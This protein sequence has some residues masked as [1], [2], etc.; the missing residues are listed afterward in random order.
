MTMKKTKNEKSNKAKREE[1]E[2]EFEI[3]FI[4]DPDIFNPF[5]EPRE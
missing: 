2:E 4:P 3:E 5:I 1:Q